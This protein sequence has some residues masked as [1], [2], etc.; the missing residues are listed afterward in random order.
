[1]EWAPPATNTQ[2]AYVFPW[3][4][5]AINP[6][7]STLAIVLVIRLLHSHQVLEGQARAS[8][9]TQGIADGLT[10][11]GMKLAGLSDSLSE[12]LMSAMKEIEKQVGMYLIPGKAYSKGTSRPP[13]HPAKFHPASRPYSASSRKYALVP[14]SFINTPSRESRPR[15]FCSSRCENEQESVL[16]SL[17]ATQAVAAAQASSFSA[18][19]GSAKSELASYMQ[20]IE[21][22]RR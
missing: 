11:T 16:A 2:S 15:S 4:S 13:T 9:Q 10:E 14:D 8:I 20:A 7:A 5:H 21:E 3:L 18:E 22:D 1:M 19:L 17:L 12:E 6:S